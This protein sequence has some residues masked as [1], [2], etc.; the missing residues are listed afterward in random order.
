MAERLVVAVLGNRNAGKSSTWYALFGS[1]VKT[2]KKLRRLML[3]TTEWVEVFLV[4]GSPE[5]REVFIGEILPTLAEDVPIIVLCSMQ[6]R[7]DV[8]QTFG[9]FVDNGF[10]MHVVWLNPGYGENAY[11]DELG[12]VPFLIERGAWIAKRDGNE[13]IGVRC[14]EIREVLFGWSWR[15]SLLKSG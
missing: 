10:D 3:N 4:S 2:G 13:N 9:Y 5:E 14:N 11:E 6:Y 12:L 7:K 8:V 1:E 15:R